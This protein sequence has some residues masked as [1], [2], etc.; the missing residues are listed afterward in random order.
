MLVNY[1]L[2]VNI[3]SQEIVMMYNNTTHK[4]ADSLRER[5]RVK[6]LWVILMTVDANKVSHEITRPMFQAGEKYQK[7]LPKVI[8]SL[9]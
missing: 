7:C 4:H 2:N 9:K 1:P 3:N 6:S 8:A 5:E